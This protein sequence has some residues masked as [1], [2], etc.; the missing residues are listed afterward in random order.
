VVG[1][2]FVF[3][4]VGVATKK[5]RDR[6]DA[7]LRFKTIQENRADCARHIRAFKSR[8]DLDPVNVLRELSELTDSHCG[9]ALKLRDAWPLA[10][11]GWV[12]IECTIKCNSNS[13][14]PETNYRITLTEYGRGI[15]NG[16][17]P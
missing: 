15:L 2:A 4:L 1:E 5:K 16:A 7:N 6:E 17:T 3:D 14:P 9:H 10:W 12:D 13:I 8:P 11:K